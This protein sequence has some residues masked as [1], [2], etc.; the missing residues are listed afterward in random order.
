MA[1]R[2]LTMVLVPVLLTA[3]TAACGLPGGGGGDV[4]F[5]SD[6]VEGSDPVALTPGGPLAQSRTRC[7]EP[8]ADEDT[9]T[10]EPTADGT[11]VVECSANA[12]DA[13][14]VSLSN[15]DGDTEDIECSP[16]GASASIDAG[17]ANTATIVFAEGA[18][19]EVGD[20]D[21][22][23]LSIDYDPAP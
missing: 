20:G 16:A 9:Y 14:H 12:L 4:I 3:G 1:R 17:P 18:A 11:V 13:V 23:R 2:R 7:I 21:G 19:A 5:C 15:V 6:S 10:V 22:Y 8:D